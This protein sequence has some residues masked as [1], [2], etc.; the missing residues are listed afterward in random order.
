MA[1][2]LD[3]I[4][5]AIIDLSYYGSPQP[6]EDQLQVPLNPELCRLLESRHIELKAELEELNARYG[7]DG[8]LYRPGFFL[9]NSPL[10]DFFDYIHFG[11]CYF[12]LTAFL[13]SM[14]FAYLADILFSKPEAKSLTKETRGFSRAQTGD[15]ITAVIPLT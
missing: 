1:G 12:M 10:P 14:Y 7:N 9:G 4:K 5:E 6:T 11:F 15:A 3:K 13:V 2:Y 8:L